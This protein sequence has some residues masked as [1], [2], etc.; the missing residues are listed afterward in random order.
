MSGSVKRTR[1][2]MNADLNNDNAIQRTTGRSSRIRMDSER[3]PT[4]RSNRLNKSTGTTGEYAPLR[5]TIDKYDVDQSLGNIMLDIELAPYVFADTNASS[6][7]VFVKK[8]MKDFTAMKE[9]C[10]AFF[11]DNNII[12]HAFSRDLQS[13]G[14]FT[15][16]EGSVSLKDN[17][18]SVNKYVEV[19]SL[20]FEIEL[21]HKSMVRTYRIVNPDVW[22]NPEKSAR[23]L[24][25]VAALS[26]SSVSDFEKYLYYWYIVKTF[27]AP[28]Y[29]L[30]IR[31]S[32]V[33]KA[34]KS[35]TNNN[36]SLPYYYPQT[37]QQTNSVGNASIASNAAEELFDNLSQDSSTIHL[38][39]LPGGEVVPADLN[40][41]DEVVPSLDDELLRQTERA[42]LQMASLSISSNNNSQTDSTNTSK[43]SV[44]SIYDMYRGIGIHAPV[45]FGIRYIVVGKNASGKNVTLKPYMMVRGAGSKS[46]TSKSKSVTSKTSKASK[47]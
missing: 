21:H 16:S 29:D 45:A 10:A 37:L 35:M 11:A 42:L 43:A 23:L 8:V 33:V 22:L 41:I 28:D 26:K 2:S 7:T 44:A 17:V 13:T 4:R 18:S 40:E 14:F 20:E 32:N 38:T 19:H 25:I 1:N 27:I 36:S 31:Y 46:K 9:V 15:Q 39:T 24:K 47:A 6:S 30:S 34:S 12:L 3:T 5:F